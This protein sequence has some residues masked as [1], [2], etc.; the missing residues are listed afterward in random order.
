MK[1]EAEFIER[2]IITGLIVS[3]D[4]HERIEKV[5][6]PTFLES[7]ELRTIADW[8]VTYFQKYNKAPDTDIQS[9]YLEQLK[10]GKIP[11]ADGQY[12]EELLEDLSDEYG[13]DM[14][15]NSAYLYDQTIKYFKS[16]EL[17]KHYREIEALN[18]MGQVDEAEKLAQSYTPTILDDTDTGL[19]LS[20]DEAL[21]RVDRAFSETGQS[22]LTY[23]GALGELWN[24]HLIRGGFV[25]FLAPEKRG[26]CITGDQRILLSDGSY[27][28]LID[29][30]KNKRKD[31]ISFDEE[32]HVFVVGEIT[33]YWENGVKPV[34][35]ITTRSGRTISVTKNHPL[36]TPDGWKELENIDIGEF[37]AVPKKCPVFGKA[38]LPDHEVRL[39]AY[40]IADGCMRE[41]SYQHEQKGQHT[42][43]HISF[44]KGDEDIRKDFSECVSRMG[45]KVVWRTEIEAA[46][47]NSD[48]NR[49]KQ[50]KNYVLHWIKT[51]GMWN[52]MSK[53][54]IIPEAIFQL[55]KSKL[56]LFL[57]TLFTCDGWVN[58]APNN[59]DYQIGYASA[60][61]TL[62]EQIHFLLSRF[63]V[64]SKLYFTDNDK[65]GS[66]TVSIADT[67]NMKLFCD[68]I[69][70][71]FK[72]EDKA[73]RVLSK[74]PN[75]RRSFLDKFPYQIARQFH[76]D[77]LMELEGRQGIDL[78]RGRH[79]RASRFRSI[80]TKAPSVREQIAKKAPL[81]RQSFQ[82]VENTKTG[83]K[84]LDSCILWDEIMLIEYQEDLPTFDLTVDKHHNFIAENIIVHNSF[85]LMEMALR[86]IRQKANVA[87]FDAGDNTEAQVLRR[88]CIYIARKS[89]KE[90][91]C[92]ERYRPVGDCIYNQ[93]DTCER[94]DRNCDHGIFEGVPLVD[95]L[96][97][98]H[99]FVNIETLREKYEE[100]P[101]YET[102]KSYGCRKR[103]GTVWLLRV[104]K[105]RPLISKQAKKELQEFFRKYK[106]RFKLIT[107][108]AGTL[109]VSE[110]R[111]S[112]DAW[113]RH[114]GFVPDIVAADYADLFSASD[115]DVSEFRHQQNHIW[116][117]LRGLSQ[118]RHVLMVSATQADTDSY[119]KGRLSMSNFSE[120]KRKLAHVTAQYGLNQD[121]A[122]REKSLGVLRIN[123]IVVRE[124]EFSSD[125]EVAILQ[126]LAAGRAYMESYSLKPTSA[127]N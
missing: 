51:H 79:E 44:S 81:M 61:K 36:L 15:F 95:F 11:K 48:E 104:K 82:E 120:D 127:N 27:M 118:E 7:P 8:C 77:I 19:E 99:Q 125:N 108:P 105:T 18:D 123:E 24:E 33:D 41:Y 85:L 59:R 90:K 46:I 121:V 54:K 112:L 9:I 66:W 117:G 100:F 126:D 124:G 42:S 63:G 101:D 13:R 23:P 75:A 20:S 74:L 58:E 16:Q 71:L 5:W 47:I 83:K 39:L 106:R 96:S 68:E 52:K 6:S 2:R 78:T 115:G 3:K 102:C 37:I 32:K 30:I 25:T 64:V 89:D 35:K 114:T 62:S 72:K 14:Q 86:A 22:V 93:L 34:Y 4:F 88:I 29:V 111:R 69:G 98:I 92:Q 116:K 12:I 60:S 122:G 67:E 53:D 97:Q 49:Y 84:Y 109:T 94:D 17:E 119:K 103:R 73:I 45:C 76:D 10:G 26:K 87:Y 55:P 50:N 31:V 107:Y 91:Y 57:Q 40:F 110:M 70:F 21:E 1:N 43:S 38:D 65:S 28:P 56:A 113:E 80:F